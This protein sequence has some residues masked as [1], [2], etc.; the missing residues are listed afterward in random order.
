MEDFFDSHVPEGHFFANARTCRTR[1]EATKHYLSTSHFEKSRP[2]NDG[3]LEVLHL[4]IHPFSMA[5]SSTERSLFDKISQCES[6]S[7]SADLT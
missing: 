6:L 2:A 5:R 4:I 7:E 1:R 3:I